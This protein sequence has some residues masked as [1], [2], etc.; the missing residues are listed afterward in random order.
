MGRANFQL[1]LGRDGDVFA[2]LAANNIFAPDRFTSDGTRFLVD[3]GGADL[4]AANFRYGIRTRAGDD[5]VY[6]TNS[7]NRFTL[8]AGNNYVDGRLGTDWIKYNSSSYETGVL[9]DLRPLIEG[10]SSITAV[11]EGTYRGEDFSDTITGIE[12]VDGTRQ[13]DTIYGSELGGS[14]IGR[15]GNDRLEGGG[16]DNF[17]ELG[18]GFDTV[19]FSGAPGGSEDFVEDFDPTEDTLELTGIAAI[20]VNTLSVLDGSFDDQVRTNF[21][22]EDFDGNQIRLR[23]KNITLE[24]GLVIASSFGV[25]S[26]NTNVDGSDS[27]V[28]GTIGDDS[29]NRV[30]GVPDTFIDFIASVGNDTYDFTNLAA[31]DFSGHFFDYE[32]LDGVRFDFDTARL[33]NFVEKGGTL[34][35]DTIVGLTLTPNDSFNLFGSDGD[36]IL[37]INL[38]PNNFDFAE[39]GFQRG[40]DTLNASGGNGVLKLSPGYGGDGAFVD[41]P[42]NLIT[43]IGDDPVTGDRVVLNLAAVDF[44]TTFLQIRTNRG[45][46]SIVGTD[47][48]EQFAPDAGTDTI[49]GGLGMD[50]MIYSI[51]GRVGEG[52][53]V[54]LEAGS[55]TGTWNGLFFTHF[56]SEVEAVQG[57]EFADVMQAASTGSL[58]KG[59]DGNDSLTGGTGDD[60]IIGGFGQDSLVGGGGADTLEG[61][62]N[63]DLLAFNGF[64]T[65]SF[66][67]GGSERDALLFQ[68]SGSFDFTGVNVSDEFANLE[69]LNLENSAADTIRLSLTNVIDFTNT[70]DALLDGIFTI[71]T[72][73]GDT[74]E[75]STA[76][77]ASFSQVDT[78]LDTDGTNLKVYDYSNGAG[79][80]ALVAVEDDVTPVAVA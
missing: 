52:L 50:T 73:T 51:G 22:F 18:P 21:D 62:E 12:S 25:T 75:L 46:D 66:L 65:G 40:Q 3:F 68:D 27:I 49:V 80:A 48:D 74:V 30:T 71:R 47:Q 69:V 63:E 78:R 55:A 4:E 64:G 19:A 11:V 72:D 60:L 34:G 35:T 6:G 26:V 17:Y 61:Q 7:D 59:N 32:G 5:E 42:N 79:D 70:A 76:G 54:D 14:F 36:D 8:E 2:D 53:D 67:D 1:Q 44:S 31:S 29:F 20:Q 38:D 9:V 58:L 45:D 41:L 77:G 33:N 56:I 37:D 23:F 16:G 10:N 13:N 28:R 43:R 24:E 39:L 57:S 15:Q